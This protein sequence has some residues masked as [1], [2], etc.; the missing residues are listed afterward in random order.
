MY[1]YRLGRRLAIACSP[2]LALTF[3]ASSFTQS[4]SEHTGI[5]LAHPGKIRG[6]CSTFCLWNGAWLEHKL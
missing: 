5:S 4:S 2:S 3:D 1:V 6:C